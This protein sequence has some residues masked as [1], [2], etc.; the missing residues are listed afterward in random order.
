MYCIFE[1]M[2]LIAH[3]F[4]YVVLSMILYFLLPLNQL[5]D[6]LAPPPNGVRL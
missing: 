3:F 4:V 2:S 1:T 6:R 5:Y